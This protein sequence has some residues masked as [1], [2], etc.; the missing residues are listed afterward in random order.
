LFM[1]F[2]LVTFTSIIKQLLISSLFIF[3][4]LDNE[5]PQPT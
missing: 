1:R 5:I 4:V 3:C 2:C